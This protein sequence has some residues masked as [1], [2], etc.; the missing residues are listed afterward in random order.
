LTVYVQYDLS[1]FY[2]KTLDE[3]GLTLGQFEY[4]YEEM[5][6]DKTRRMKFEA[7]LHGV[8]LDSEEFNEAIGETSKPAEKMPIFESLDKY[9]EL[10][11]EERE[12]LT[13]EMKSKHQKW[14]KDLSTN[15]S[16]GL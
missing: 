13:K 2:V 9:K 6:K 7:A 1:H 5:Q 11:K 16:G 8:N 3:G 10:S 12:N 14:H 4:L 15:M